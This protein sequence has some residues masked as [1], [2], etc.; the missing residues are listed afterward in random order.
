[1]PGSAHA[2]FVGCQ[3]AANYGENTAHLFVAQA[4]ARVGCDG[5]RLDTVNT[6]LSR[7][8]ATMTLSTNDSDQEKLCFYGGMWD[9]LVSALSSEYQACGLD[10]PFSCL[11]RVALAGFAGSMLKSIPSSLLDPDSFDKAAVP[12]V[13]T[14]DPG[15]D[16]APLCA[17]LDDVSP[18]VLAIRR[19]GGTA[20]TQYGELADDIAQLVCGT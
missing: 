20:A 10:P 11:N 2:A 13:Y 1:M 17:P 4:F 7:A 19:K 18:C 15:D 8:L 12:R 16:G 6:A 9:G 14:T 5:S 3:D